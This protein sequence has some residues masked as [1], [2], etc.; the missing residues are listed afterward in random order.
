MWFVGN[1]RILMPLLITMTIGHEDFAIPAFPVKI[2]YLSALSLGYLPAGTPF[3]SIGC[4][5]GVNT[6]RAPQ[7]IPA[8]GFPTPEICH[9]FSYLRLSCLQRNPF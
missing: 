7:K 8:R 6:F 4:A 1:K 9:F 5:A 2:E 3:V